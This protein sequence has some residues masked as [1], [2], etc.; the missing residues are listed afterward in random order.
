[1]IRL[2]SL[3]RKIFGLKKNKGVTDKLN[4]KYKAGF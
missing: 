1:M 3:K 2:L 4:G